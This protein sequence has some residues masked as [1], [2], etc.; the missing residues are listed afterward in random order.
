T[1]GATAPLL[2]SARPFL[3]S[4]TSGPISSACGSA[5]RALR[6]QLSRV[7]D[8]AGSGRID[9][10]ASGDLNLD[11]PLKACLVRRADVSPAGMAVSGG[12]SRIVRCAEDFFRGHFSE[13]V[14]VAQL[15]RAAGVSER[16]LRNAF[17]DVYTTSPKRYM[18][19]WQLHQVRRV[20]RSTNAD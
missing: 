10:L 16:S 13:G 5:A 12:R 18:K 8:A 2:K 7:R 3:E 6:D 19:L 4:N 1:A 14:S 15:S 20:L 17:Y 9:G 11:A